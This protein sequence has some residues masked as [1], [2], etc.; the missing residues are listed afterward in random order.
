MKTIVE[1]KGKLYLA[2]RGEDIS[3]DSCPLFNECD[4]EL[5]ICKQCGL[6]YNTFIVGEIKLDIEAGAQWK[7]QQMIDKACDLLSRMVCDITYKDLQGDSTEHYDTTEFVEDFRKAM[8][9]TI[10]E[11]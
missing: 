7:E 6:Q 8:S 1:Y 10:K 9:E 5:C 4:N 2:K 11:D 3:C